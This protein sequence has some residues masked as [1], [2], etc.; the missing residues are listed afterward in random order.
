MSW[1]PADGG[2]RDDDSRQLVNRLL[3][4]SEYDQGEP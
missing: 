1:T 2:R 3:A 4:S